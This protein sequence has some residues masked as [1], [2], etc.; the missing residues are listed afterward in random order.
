MVL[1]NHRQENRGSLFKK[2]YGGYWGSDCSLV[3]SDTSYPSMKRSGLWSHHGSIA[4][5]F[6]GMLELNR[7]AR[8]HARGDEKESA[9]LW[10]FEQQI[11]ELLQYYSEKNESLALT[12]GNN[13]SSLPKVNNDD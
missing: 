11:K 7:R 12:M 3:D 2:M 9:T 1:K 5:C 13:I 4:I 8:T 10:E 6:E